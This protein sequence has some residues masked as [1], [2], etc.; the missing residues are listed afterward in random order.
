MLNEAQQKQ[1]II[2]NHFL[3]EASMKNAGS[4]KYEEISLLTLTAK[5]IKKKY[6]LNR[7]KLLVIDLK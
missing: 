7:L 5:N 3:K 2:F 6:L 4:K 1:L